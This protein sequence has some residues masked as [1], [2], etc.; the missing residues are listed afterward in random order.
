MT[1]APEE[2]HFVPAPADGVRASDAERDEVAAVLSE[3][4]AQGRLTSTV[5]PKPDGDEDG[6]L[7]R[8][9]GKASFSKIVVYRSGD[10]SVNPWIWSWENRDN[11]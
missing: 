2:K 11:R 7:I 6:P 8:I 5:G 3:A 1:S 10:R 4:L 9:T